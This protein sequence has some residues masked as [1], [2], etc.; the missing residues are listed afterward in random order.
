MFYIKVCNIGERS[1]VLKYLSSKDVQAAFHYVPLHSAIAGKKYSKFQGDD[2][3][4]THE[5]ECLIRLPLWYGMTE[6]ETDAVA[7]A[8]IEYYCES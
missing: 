6:S 4:T 7:N 8:L 2:T 1:T 3:Y 5:S